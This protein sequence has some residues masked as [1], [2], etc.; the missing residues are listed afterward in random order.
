MATELQSDAPAADEQA[1]P[2][3]QQLDLEAP[4]RQLTDAL[5][6]YEAARALFCLERLVASISVANAVLALD[7]E[8]GAADGAAGE[9]TD[10]SPSSAARCLT[11]ALPQ[12][13]EDVPSPSAAAS[14]RDRFLRS[15]IAV[16]AFKSPLV[17]E[18]EMSPRRMRAR[19]RAQASSERDTASPSTTREPV[20]STDK[21]AAQGQA[22]EEVGNCARPELFL[23]PAEGVVL[24]QDPA[25]EPGP[26]PRLGDDQ[27]V[28]FPDTSTDDD[29]MLLI[30]DNTSIDSD[31][32]LLLVEEPDED[33]HAAA[34]KVQAAYRGHRARLPGLPDETSETEDDEDD[35]PVQ[36]PDTSTDDDD[37]PV[38]PDDTSTDSDGHL[39]LVEDEDLHVAALKV[40]AAYRGHRARSPGLPDETSE[41]D[42]DDEPVQLPDTSTDDDMPVIPDNTST[43]SDGH[44]LLVEEPDEDLHAAALKVQAAYR[45]H[46][47][48]LPGLPDETSETEDDEDDRPRIDDRT[49]SGA[50]PNERG[51][52]S[53]DGGVQAQSG[54][55]DCPANGQGLDRASVLEEGVPP[56]QPVAAAPYDVGVALLI[57]PKR[58]HMRNWGRAR[59]VA[60]LQ[61]LDDTEDEDDS[62]DETETD[63]EN[64]E[65]A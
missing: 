56:T 14:P 20:W 52:V 18:V 24:G 4:R 28:E 48:R 36:L 33:L 37:M 6:G 10:Q 50:V 32:H 53:I 34:L 8:S 54:K 38:I 13:E 25:P 57:G 30:P 21:S 43:D 40:Q 42:E 15:T 22:K 26:Q 44:L 7:S 9:G 31:G 19:Q 12:R 16:A 47:A 1:A 2:Q 59:L 11:K 49:A 29:D 51:D 65:H 63:V 60:A 61:H 62:L 39:L 55:L 17:H 45:G 23:V 27:R 46:R 35:E 64:A 58:V 41:D 3:E 5:Q